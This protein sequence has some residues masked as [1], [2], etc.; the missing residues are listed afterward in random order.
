MNADEILRHLDARF[1]W[2]D[3]GNIAPDLGNANYRFAD[4]RLTAFRSQAHWA[5]IFEF[6]G[7][8]AGGG[9]DKSLSVYVYG[10]F[11]VEEGFF[12]HHGG[13]L[14][15]WPED[16]P[17]E[18]QLYGSTISLLLRGEALFF[19]PS[20]EE[21]AAAGLNGSPA[22]AGH[23]RWMIDWVRF[24]CHRLD[25]PFFLSEDVLR[26]LLDAYRD[27]DVPGS[28]HEMRLLLQTRDWQHPD[29]D[30]P[31][32]QVPGFQALAHALAT[33][34]LSPWEAINPALFNTDWRLWEDRYS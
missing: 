31:P 23:L 4:A 6:P 27:P 18:A 15:G 26:F 14:F 16:K 20:P 3:I 21:Y 32:S 7:C 11:L 5:L 17:A 30:E 33:G 1:D 28:S 19:S 24:L 34:D 25:H 8:H 2:K 22:A 9:D 10:N 12:P 29:G 13:C